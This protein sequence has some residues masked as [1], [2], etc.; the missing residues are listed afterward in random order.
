M[1]SPRS[2]WK[3]TYSVW[4]A[5]FFREAIART[6]GD[7]MGWFWML[8]EPIAL[9]SFMTAV[10]GLGGAAHHVDGADFVAW[11]MIGLLG[12]FLF[13]ENLQRALGAIQANKG[14]F[15]Y[16]QVH[17]VDPVLV[18]CFLEGL[19]KTF[20][21]LLFILAG[22]LL[23]IDLIAFDPLYA[24]ASWFAL[25]ILGVGSAVTASAAAELIPEVGHLT[26]IMMLPLLIVSGV[27][28]PISYLP[29]DIQTILL[30][31]PVVHGLELLRVGFFENYRSVSGVS[32]VYLW[33]WNLN[34]LAFGLLLHI[35]FGQRLKAQ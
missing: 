12:F 6:S 7:R 29:P 14:L 10:R 11:A 22:Q 19:L 32:V 31:N 27:I 18:R 9:V 3:I 34:L 2:H 26:R 30:F 1:L 17:T 24:L 21:L 5:L 28:F 33:L 15:A 13:R 8:L 23:D 25:W 35:R 16:R 4:Y 20:I